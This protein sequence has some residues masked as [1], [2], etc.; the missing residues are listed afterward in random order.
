MWRIELLGEPRVLGFGHVITQFESKRA[1]A[2]LAYLALHPRTRHSRE[3]LADRIWPDA[4]VEAARNRLK[5]ALSSLRRQLEP[6]GLQRGCVID[7]DRSSIGLRPGSFT[8]DVTELREAMEAGDEALAQTLLKGDL[9]PGYYDEWLDDI[10]FEIDS[11]G[12]EL[13]S[14]FPAQKASVA[15]PTSPHK[16]RIPAEATSFI[17]RESELEEIGIL[18]DRNRWVTVTGFGGIGKTRLAQ[19]AAR[20]VSDADVYYV[21]AA[22]LTD[23]F[24]LAAAIVR[25]MGSDQTETSVTTIAQLTEGTKTLF[26]LDN[27]E[28]IRSGAAELIHEL[29]ESAPETS[30]LVTSRVPLRTPA[31]CEYHLKPLETPSDS[32]QTLAVLAANPSVRLFIDRARRSRPD[33]QLTVGN[34]ESVCHLCQRLDGI[35][36]AI[37]LCAA[38]SHL[39]IKTLVRRLDTELGPLSTETQGGAER[40]GSLERVFDASRS[41]LSAEAAT[42]LG[43]LSVFS[44]GWD[45]ELLSAV[46]EPA[47]SLEAFSELIEVSL[48]RPDNLTDPPR[49]HLLESVR[50]FAARSLG[51]EAKGALEDRFC[52]AVVRLGRCSA[53]IEPMP[54][55]D[56]SDQK[57]WIDLLRREWLNV[58]EAIKILLAKGRQ[59][60]AVRLA[61]DTE[62]YW[63]PYVE[64]SAV[65]SLVKETGLPWAR[66]L[67]L[68]YL[69]TGQ[70][71]E[72]VNR[73][74]E[75]MAETS[76]PQLAADCLLR[77]VKRKVLRQ[78][79]QGVADM[80]Y[81]AA[82]LFE[83]CGDKVGQGQA[84]H[85]LANSAIVAGDRDLTKRS[86]SHAEELFSQAGSQLNVVALAYTQSRESYVAKDWPLALERIN[87]CHA[88]AKGIG[89]LRLLGRTSNLHGVV[90]RNTGKEA[91]SR[92]YFFVAML[93]NQRIR[94]IR[95]SHVPLWNLALSLGTDGRHREAVPVMGWAT[96]ILED[97]KMSADDTELVLLREFRESADVALG[98]VLSAHLDAIGRA[99]SL[100]TGVEFL[101][102]ALREELDLYDFVVQ[103]T[104][105]LLARI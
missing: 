16:V 2:L 70:A 86:L 92:I 35:P 51:E 75:R 105:N 34:A 62:W 58:T 44:A 103:D 84:L 72:A 26:V 6:P 7:A 63:A 69:P 56:I 17:G 3:V 42:L 98:S 89:N 80:A 10:R 13:L 27:L 101:K 11:L 25:T 32:A 31:E 49:F 38:W 65:V 87:R 33:F 18:L 104:L 5:Q 100:D 77:A 102:E 71:P 40:Q 46:A 61:T 78:D 39:G 97:Y 68:T 85:V 1:V 93:A 55:Y 9:L 12:S 36:L 52:N 66:V 53:A 24:Q 64:S 76:D 47:P 48:V 90:L 95:G 21:P 83:T 30:V 57:G 91:E 50:L 28:Q 81:R 15:M 82:N 79:M 94:E 59:H 22:N 54:E 88:L 45:W 41:N 67:E 29:L 43:Q 19:R 96:Q 60:D 99:H 73:E 14:A 20:L 23:S 37:E 4:T 8:C 74:L